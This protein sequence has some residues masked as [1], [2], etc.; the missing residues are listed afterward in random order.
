MGVP[1]LVMGD[2]GS[3]KTTSLRNFEPNEIT[4]LNVSSKLLPFKGK[5]TINKK[6]ATYNDIANALKG[7]YTNTF[8]IDDAS[9]LMAF[10]SFARAKE[11]G[12]AK[13]T[14]MAKDFSDMLRFI[15]DSTPNDT[16]VYILT[17]IEHDQNETNDR[18]KMKTIGKMLDS[19]LTVEG[20]F[21]VVL[22]AV[23]DNGRFEFIT[24]SDGKS[25]AKSPMGMFEEDRIDNDLKK[26][27]DAVRD[28]WG[29][30]SR[31]IYNPK[32]TTTS[33]KEVSEK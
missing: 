21:N 25:T 22:L 28:Y 4:F 9:Y 14:D 27:D 16:V 29:L 33:A 18:I 3:G 17:H 26:V 19:Q 30:A 10:E 6:G 31:K 7:Q 32:K 1:I 11:V 24:H 23:A 13:F 15:N 12:Y 8:V 5:F 20:L 2:S